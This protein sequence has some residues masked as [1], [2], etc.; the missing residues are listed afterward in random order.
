MSDERRTTR[1]NADDNQS[2]VIIDRRAADGGK[3]FFPF[4]TSS[5]SSSPLFIRTTIIE[6]LS[7]RGAQANRNPRRRRTSFYSLF[8][9]LSSLRLHS[10][11]IISLYFF[12]VANAVIILFDLSSHADDAKSEWLA[13]FALFLTEVSHR[14]KRDRYKSVSFCWRPF[15]SSFR[16]VVDY[17]TITTSIT[18][19][20][21]L[22]HQLKTQ[23]HGKRTHA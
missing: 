7:S 8:D 15:F 9:V 18:T 5:S 17:L 21:S 2:S 19:D 16:R 22:S 14:K 23:G 12:A 3:S 11:I 20:A 4:S 6:I 10:V 13:S 1:R